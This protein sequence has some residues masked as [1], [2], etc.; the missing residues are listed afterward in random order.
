MKKL[1]ISC[2]MK[3]RTE[4]NIKKSMEKMHRIAEIV[5]DE[6]LEVI[7]THIVDNPPEDNNRAVWYLGKS[8]QL[9][10]QADY[11]IG[12]EYSDFFRGCEVENT[13]ARMYGIRST[14]V[15]IREMMPDAIEVERMYWENCEKEC[16]PVIC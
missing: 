13:V 6:E 1:F 14:H 12:V 5:F 8:I 11:F 4:E 7:P 2:P 16:R 15:N 9:M 10:A 3:G